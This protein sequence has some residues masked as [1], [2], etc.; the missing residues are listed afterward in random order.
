MFS[1]AHVDGVEQ[2][3]KD[4]MDCLPWRLSAFIQDYHA[5]GDNLSAIDLL[6]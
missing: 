1:S 5:S 6:A 3:T 4:P 2:S